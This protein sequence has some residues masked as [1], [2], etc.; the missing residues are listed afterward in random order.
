MTSTGKLM[1]DEEDFDTES[2]DSTNVTGPFNCLL[3]L[4]LA[5]NPVKCNKCDQVYC[6]TCLFT[7]VQNKYNFNCFKNCGGIAVSK[8]TRI[9]TNILNSIPFKC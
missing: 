1:I 4:G 8:L 7:T 5:I 6:L 3:C 9:E 2:F